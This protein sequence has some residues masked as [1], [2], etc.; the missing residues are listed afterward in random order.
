MSNADRN[1]GPKPF[2]TEDK[3]E[4]LIEMR[5][6]GLGNVEIAKILGCSQGSVQGQVWKLRKAGFVIAP[7]PPGPIP[8]CKAAPRHFE[9]KPRAVR[10]VSSEPRPTPH[11][12]TI[13]TPAARTRQIIRE[14]A[15]I[16]GVQVKDIIDGDRTPK[17]VAA[18][19]Q[20][21]VALITAKPHLSYPQIGRIFRMDHTTAVHHA[22]VAG[23]TSRKPSPNQATAAE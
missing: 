13:I 9:R 11:T 22:Q 21:I 6:A 12:D 8:G 14:V 16:Y 5:A 20:A 18:R 7:R 2:W 19:R 4:R 17:N 15:D 23:L 3:S 10:P 1:Q